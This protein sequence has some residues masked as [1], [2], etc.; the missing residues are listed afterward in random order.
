MADQTFDSFFAQTM[1][2][3]TMAATP[4][5]PPCTDS[6]PATI[7]ME[8]LEVFDASSPHE[9]MMSMSEPSSTPAPSG[10]D[11]KS[12]K[13]RKSWGQVLPE[14]KTSLPPRK[15]A[16][17]D[18]EKEQRRIERVK[19]NR[20]AA[21]NSRERK[22]QEYELLEKEKQRMEADLNRYQE[23]M[24][25]MKAEL[26]FY[27]A[28]YPGQVPSPVF[29]L[30]TAMTKDSLATI[31]PTQT[32]THL[33]SPMSMSNDS[34]DS[35]RESSY[36]P[37]TP[38]STF[39]AT[40][41]FDSTQYSAAVLCDLQCQSISR[42]ASATWAYLTLFHL[43]L[44]STKSLLSSMTFSSSTSFQKAAQQLALW[45]PLMASLILQA[46][47]SVQPSSAMTL[48]QPLMDLLMPL[49]QSSLICRVPSARLLSA[50]G[51]S[52]RSLST[53]DVAKPNEGVSGVGSVDGDCGSRPRGSGGCGQ[54]GRRKSV[55]SLGHGRLGW[56]H[57]AL[58]VA[59]SV[60]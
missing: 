28:K 17:T 41:D 34:F 48:C 5:T 2:T 7:K 32:S 8:Q 15:R 33:T 51:F 6:V 59:A 54:F 20:L 58:Q 22:R 10:S 38:P 44:L 18:D 26:E 30:S 40:P 13:K 57:S 35:P 47:S 31:C 25:Q 21:H 16:K 39:E 52:Q 53:D 45:N 29:D 46:T 50:T 4:L 55:T 14:P 42:T 24:A 3:T 56:N 9:S 37:E 43:T 23:Q 1:N 27:R 60:F 19:R 11:S 36:Q 49:M 12:V